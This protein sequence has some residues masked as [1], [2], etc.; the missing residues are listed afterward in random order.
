[1]TRPAD[2]LA[3]AL[4]GA[5]LVRIL[6]D[7]TRLAGIIVET[8][9][10]LGPEDK[11]AHSH[12]SRRTERTEPMYAA[13]GTAYVYFTYGMH[14]CMNVS[15]G[16]IDLPHAVLIRALE[17]TEGIET[18]FRHRAGKD[19]KRPMKQRDLCNGP[20]KL[21]KALAIDKAFT[22]IDMCQSQHLFLERGRTISDDQ[23]AT[24]ARIGIA[25]AG[26]WTEKHLRW[27]I[28]HNEHV[29]KGLRAHDSAR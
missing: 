4:L 11:A 27:L 12:K 20:A 8:E 16:K 14:Y 5:R 15:A 28:P 3:R 22:G 1:M 9:A 26:E 24:D 7:S 23:V 10:Y 2:E 21:C 18:M 25:N 13:P 29:S 6:P 19:P 17:P